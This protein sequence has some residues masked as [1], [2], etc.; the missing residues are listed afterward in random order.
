MSGQTNKIFNRSLENF[1]NCPNNNGQI[2]YS[3]G[4]FQPVG[5]VVAQ[6]STD[7][8]NT[9]ATSTVCAVPSNVAG[10]Q[11][12]KTGSNYAGFVISA[13]GSTI[14][15]REFL[16]GSLEDTLKANVNYCFGFYANLAN[17]SQYATDLI[18]FKFTTDSFKMQTADVV[19]GNFPTNFDS[20]YLTP[21]HADTA[22]W[23]LFERVYQ[24]S[25][26]EKFITIG[27]FNLQSSILYYNVNPLGSL[28]YP[29]YYFD[30][31]F[32]YEITN[33]NTR[34]D[35]L[36]NSPG[37]VQ[38]GQNNDTTAFYEWW[39]HAGIVDTN[40]INPIANVTQT[41]MY[42]VKKTQC[43]VVSVDSILVTVSPI[44]IKENQINRKALISMY[45]N[46]AS[47]ELNLVFGVDVEQIQIDIVNILGEKQE[48]KSTVT[49][50]GV[51][52]LNTALLNSGTYICKI[53]QL[54]NLIQ[55]E[56]IVIIK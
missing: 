53:Y 1:S 11:L 9:C 51:I 37:L 14:N 29:Y 56:K 45:P 12:P 10:W 43:N 30:D 25:G 4:W 31:F 54:S 49:K 21:N 20:I 3:Y 41:T 16:E 24:A 18:N 6:S 40:S 50:N 13:P 48:V 28:P 23:H 8:F 38:L 22:N 35:T 15:S 44:G 26:G 5:L 47:N 32:L 46:P 34:N 27:N 7:Y 36:I 17:Q 52:N 39:P 55:N 33:A 19:N 2:Y 42:Y